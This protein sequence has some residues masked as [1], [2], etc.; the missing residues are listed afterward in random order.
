M[1]I[2]K[3]P[4]SFLRRSFLL[5]APALWLCIS[6]SGQQ[7]AP[8]D[9]TPARNPDEAL[10]RAVASE[11]RLIAK[12]KTV[13]PVVE[14]YIQQMQR[15]EDMGSIPKTDNYFLGK[16]DLS[17]EVSQ[18]SFIPAP[19]FF[20][21]S[22]GAF[23]KF[24]SPDFLPRGFAQM[25]LMDE[26]GF[27]RQHYTFQYVRREFLGDVRCLVFDVVPEKSA[28]KGRFLGRIWVEDRDFH[29]VRF[30]GT[31]GGSSMRTHYTHFDSW[32]V[33]CGPDLWLPA[34][35]YTE[36]GS[37]PMNGGLRRVAFKAQTRLWGYQSKKQRKSEEFTNMT[38][39]TQGVNDKSEQ[40]SDNSP[41][42]EQ[43]LWERQAEDNILERLQ[44]AGLMAPPGDVDK[45]LD[46]IITN[47][48]ITNNVNV[49]P[50][51]RARVM[52]TT[53]LESIYVGHTI[54]ISRGLLDVLPD[55]A[56]L[57]AVV[58]HEM[59]HVLLGHQLDTK[60]AF[61]DRL[62]F[63]DDQTLERV[64]LSRS[65]R[66]EDAADEKAIELLK[67]SPYADKLPKAGLFLK[68]LSARGDEM[69]HLIRPLLGN[70]MAANSKDLRLSGLMDQ[71]PPLE[72]ERVDQIAALPL[73]ARVKMDPWNDHLSLMKTHNVPL[74]SAREKLPFEITPFMLHLTRESEGSGSAAPAGTEGTP[75]PPSSENQPAGGGG[76]PPVVDR[77]GQP[78]ASRR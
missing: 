75:P 26:D 6:A 24:F 52:L 77:S 19:G 42:E 50:E 13:Q 4:G 46:T 43:R 20:K 33:N 41:V 67:K 28:G 47:L 40:A 71:A 14:T 61:W 25:V 64:Q 22:I 51:M 59:G 11:T 5:A 18:D 66:E 37:M 30:N 56:T 55:E 10:N 60:Y 15:D 2:F 65:E 23:T 62:L 1:L 68:M 38:V 70:R 32:R 74:L 35:V 72:L 27:D 49:Q 69:P 48:E 21:R 73:G 54:V 36:E 53:P 63:K 3:Y 76:Q 31:Y 58:A 39:D 45:V 16:L 78:A 29:I 34:Y 17:R 44:D 9:A 12:L 57:A 7:P 8:G